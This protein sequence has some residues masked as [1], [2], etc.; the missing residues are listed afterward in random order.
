M[1]KRVQT[2]KTVKI[3]Q[4]KLILPRGTPGTI[5]EDLGKEW[6]IRFGLMNYAKIK[7]E[8]SLIQLIK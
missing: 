4:S 2:T 3:T 7:K 5:V 1:S 8:S 6:V